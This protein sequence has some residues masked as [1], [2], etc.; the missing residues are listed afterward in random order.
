MS[1]CALLL[2]HRAHDGE[3]ISFSFDKN[4]N[5]SPGQLSAWH[6]IWRTAYMFTTAD[7]VFLY[8]CATNYQTI[9]S[10]SIKVVYYSSTEAHI[11][12]CPPDNI[13]PINHSLTRQKI[14]RA[15]RT[16]PS[17]SS[18]RRIHCKYFTLWLLIIDN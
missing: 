12:T 7:H 16:S 15:K 8:N 3:K 17:S 14:I 4:C 5:S 1:F 10:H 6:H 18:R 2:L 11:V 9:L 13:N